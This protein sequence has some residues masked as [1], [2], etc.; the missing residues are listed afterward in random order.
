VVLRPTSRSSQIYLR[1]E[2]WYGIEG[3]F[4]ELLLVI[5]L[6]MNELRDMNMLFG[7]GF[8]SSLCVD[9]IC[10]CFICFI[11]NGRLACMEDLKVNGFDLFLFPSYMC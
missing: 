8:D 10:K 3:G 9:V 7:F 6:H 5:Y 2:N 4:Y 11:Y 1:L